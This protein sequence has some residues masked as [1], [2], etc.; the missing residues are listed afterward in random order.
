MTYRLGTLGLIAA[1]VLSLPSHAQDEE[2][3]GEEA[4]ASG[5]KALLG[6]SLYVSPMFNYIKAADARG[7]KDG[8]GGQLAIGKSL[9]S[10]LNLELTAGYAML[11]GK[12]GGSDAKLTSVGV[13]AMVFPLT[14]LPDLYVPV[15][16]QRGQFEKHPG[17]ITDYG[18]T[19]FDIG[20]GYLIG[21]GDF[22]ALRAEVKYRVDA[23]GRE[24]AG[25]TPDQDKHF[26]EGVASLGLLIPLGSKAAAPAEAPAEE[27]APVEIVPAGDADGDGVTDD[28]DQC[29]DTPAGTVVNAQ[30]CPD[31]PAAPAC[32]PPGPGEGIDANGCAVPATI[33]LRGVNFELDSA[34]LTPNAKTILDEV[35]SSLLAVQTIQVEVQGHTSS[36][37]SDAYNL[38]LSD[39]RAEAVRQYLIGRG[40]ASERMTV[41]GYGET[42]PVADNDTEAGRELN[43]RVELKV[44]SGGGTEAAPTST[45]TAPA[46]EAVPAE[47]EVAPAE[48]APAAEG[49]AA[50][51]EGEAAPVEGEAAPVEGE[52]APAEAAPAEAAPAEG[53]TAPVEGETAPAEG[54]AAPTPVEGETAP[55]VVEAQPAQ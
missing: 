4:P 37:A 45:E 40:V 33:V 52:A 51:V 44:T 23:H 35:A 21:L 55:E 27:A 42:T 31:V 38:T 28:L 15:V 29:P 3:S 1:M 14:S 12:S 53:E 30:G 22:G 18:T 7:T 6:N 46:A 39:N 19:L 47:G 20:L 24:A 2:S 9:T 16:L 10:G 5:A 11:D 36:E 48:A 54:E 26:Y 8:L 25:T 50:P 43:R 49:E 32:P 13:G 41:K 34:K 17:P